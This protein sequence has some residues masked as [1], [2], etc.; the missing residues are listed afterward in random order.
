MQKEIETWTERDDKS[1]WMEEGGQTTKT[2]G[3]IDGKTRTN[4]QA[5]TRRHR[6]MWKDT[7]TDRLIQT[8]THRQRQTDE[9]GH[10]PTDR[11][12]MTN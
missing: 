7:K 12:R 2:D 8:N 11:R 5:D 4:G 3:K 10:I 9:D 6:H 1:I